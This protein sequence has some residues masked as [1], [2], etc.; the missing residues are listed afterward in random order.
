[1]KFIT[2]V[3]PVWSSRA[4]FNSYSAAAICGLALASRRR[5]RQ[6]P[7][8]ARTIRRD[9]VTIMVRIVANARPKAMAVASCYHHW[10]DGAPTEISCV[11]KSIFTARRGK[12][13][14]R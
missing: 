13:A 4:V 7:T 6:A 8:L 3:G 5:V 2:G 9:G 14:A 12:T 1:M 10:V 11:T